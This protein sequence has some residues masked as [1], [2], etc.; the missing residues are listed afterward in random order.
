MRSVC[1]AR[2]PLLAPVFGDDDGTPAA[3]SRVPPRQRNSAF[4][5]P[6][7]PIGVATKRARNKESAPGT[8]SADGEIKKTASDYLSEIDSLLVERFAAARANGHLR[9]DAN[10]EFVADLVRAGSSASE[11][12]VIAA[13]TID[14][15]Q[16]LNC[17]SCSDDQFTT[18]HFATPAARAERGQQA[19]ASYAAIRGRCAA[20]RGGRAGL[21][22]R[23]GTRSW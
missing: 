8:G 4:R 19:A 5:N 13:R 17:G 20:S 14:F 16:Q 12:H 7:A 11:R 6:S 1:T 2:S 18:L 22:L 9:G 15:V 3:Q 21:R 23:Y 10:P